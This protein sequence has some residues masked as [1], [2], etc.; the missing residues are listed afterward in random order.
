M[1]ESVRCGKR[2]VHAVVSPSKLQREMQSTLFHAQRAT[3]V[4]S[5]SH[6]RSITD[7]TPQAPFPDSFRVS[8]LVPK[9][10]VFQ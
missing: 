4:S 6:L 5:L 7:I 9:E 1:S 8:Q 3:L 10:I 2:M